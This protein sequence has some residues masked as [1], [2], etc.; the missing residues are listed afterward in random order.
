MG[1]QDP[2]LRIVN[3][4][5]V[6]MQATRL[7][8]YAHPSRDFVTLTA[9]N[10]ARDGREKAEGIDLLDRKNKLNFLTMDQ[11]VQFYTQLASDDYPVSLVLNTT[12][13]TTNPLAKASVNLRVNAHDSNDTPDIKIY[14]SRAI[15]L[16]NLIKTNFSQG[17]VFNFESTQPLLQI[18]NHYFRSNLIF[19]Y[20]GTEKYYLNNKTIAPIQV[21]DKV[22]LLSTFGEGEGYVGVNYR[23]GWTAF[24]MVDGSVKIARLNADNTLNESCSKRFYTAGKFMFLRFGRS[25]KVM[26]L[27]IL[28]DKEDGDILQVT[29]FP[30]N[31]TKI[32]NTTKF[33]TTRYAMPYTYYQFSVTR[34][35]DTN[36]FVLAMMNILRNEETLLTFYTNNAPGEINL[37]KA[38]FS[39]HDIKFNLAVEDFT[40][41][42]VFDKS[43]QTRLFFQFMIHPLQPNMT[44]VQLDVF[45]QRF[46]YNT[47]LDVT[48]DSPNLYPLNIGF[49]RSTVQYEPGNTGFVEVKCYIALSG[50]AD[51]IFMFRLNID[52]D[53]DEIINKLNT[54]NKIPKVKSFLNQT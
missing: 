6:D 4:S 32:T 42:C 25:R 18:T 30:T 22:H 45:S 46:I 14:P 36:V 31:L 24:L 39:S 29:S 43:R 33:S 3:I 23:L 26:Y 21:S 7:S 19:R 17:N 35:K 13:N 15:N 16:L 34:C 54:T 40:T 8:S 47:N 2:R 9:Y 5:K 44:T 41:M 49:L 52:K 48:P 20:K 53:S 27:F 1:L 10:R 50:I 28:I 38:T 51:R 37:N 12:S 11:K